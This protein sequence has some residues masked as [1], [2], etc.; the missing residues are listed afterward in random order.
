MTMSI[1]Q[2][3]NTKTPIVKINPALND[4]AGKNL[5]PEKLRKANETLEKFGVPKMN[6]QK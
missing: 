3:N 1:K 4:L 6:D 5:F 2:L